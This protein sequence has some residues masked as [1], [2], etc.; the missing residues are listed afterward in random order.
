M[1]PTLQS[2]T[3]TREWSPC[4][5]SSPCFCRCFYCLSSR[6]FGGGC[7]VVCVFW[8]WRCR[9]CAWSG[10]RVQRDSPACVCLAFL[11]APWFSHVALLAVAEASACM[12]PLDS[13]VWAVFLCC[14]PY[15]LCVQLHLPS[16]FHVIVY[17]Y[18][19]P[20]PRP[21]RRCLKCHVF[22]SNIGAVKFEQCTPTAQRRYA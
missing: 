16:P 11:G 22:C 6:C 19:S 12:S 2:P 5:C 15:Q 17:F 13:A 10:A 9:S 18:S 8:R 7:C 21:P 3:A 20:P 14:R 1:A 4:S